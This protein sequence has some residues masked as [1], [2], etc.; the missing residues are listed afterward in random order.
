VQT[1]L[2]PSLVR[3]PIAL[4]L[5]IAVVLV[6][7]LRTMRDQVDIMRRVA[8]DDWR[9]ARDDA[10]ALPSGSRRARG[11]VVDH[12]AVVL[13]IAHMVL[14]DLGAARR[15]LEGAGQ[16]RLA[17]PL[18]AVVER[19]LASLDRMAGSPDAALI[20]LA[21]PEA[22]SRGDHW[23]VDSQLALVHLSIG[24]GAT[25]EHHATAAIA[26]IRRR[27]ARALPSALR[28]AHEADL[29][30]VQCMLV[31]ARLLQGDLVGA[32]AVWA[33]HCSPAHKP[34]VEGQLAETEAHLA[35]ARGD[36]AAARGLADTALSRYEG[37]GGAID[38]TRMQVLRAGIARD[39]VALDAAEAEL[40]RQGALGYLGEVQAARREIS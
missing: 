32:E 2:V 29:A 18:R 3:S 22:T 34:Y 39:A 26:V 1:A 36:R 5:T 21:H 30:Q 12:A 33:D 13:G 4:L 40:R 20:R 28:G 10:T 6:A 11:A 35:L 7:Y 31:R 14:G 8:N 17:A 19:Q 23:G 25:A 9:G 27:V 24:D 37:V 38:R 16:R 15:A